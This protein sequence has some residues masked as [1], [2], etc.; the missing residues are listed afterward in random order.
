MAAS[1]FFFF[2]KHFFPEY[3]FSISGAAVTKKRK[4]IFQGTFVRGPARR[5]Q[6]AAPLRVRREPLRRPADVALLCHEPA[7]QRG[8][9]EALA[10]EPRLLG[11]E[12]GGVRPRRDLVD[13][14][15]E[16]VEL[17][18]RRE[19]RRSGSGSDSGSGQG[20]RNRGVRQNRGGGGGSEPAGHLGRGAVKRRGG[21][22]IKRRGKVIFRFSFFFFFFACNLVSLKKE[23]QLVINSLPFHS[24]FSL[25]LLAVSL[26]LSC[27][28][29][30][31]SSSAV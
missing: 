5:Q 28:L 20:R 3:F 18:A 4:T 31:C 13:S 7:R 25:N 23:N 10:R 12:Q 8:V 21:G 19:R 14:F 11:G 29:A 17:L 24:L 26:S 16:L 9:V 1:V 6:R 15:A 22:G 2:F 27:F 30:V